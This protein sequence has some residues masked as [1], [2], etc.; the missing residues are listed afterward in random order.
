MKYNNQFYI[1][2]SREIFTPEY[3]NLSQNAKWLFVVLN[4]LEHRF[5]GKNED[6]FIRSNEQLAKDTGMSLSTLKIAKKELKENGTELVQMW[7]A[8][9]RNVKTNKL[10]TERYT[11][12]RI[13]K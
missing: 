9:Y 2:L 1:Q 7:Q 11:A 6:F 3:A 12:Y 4:E 8:H 13:L 5:T 10:S